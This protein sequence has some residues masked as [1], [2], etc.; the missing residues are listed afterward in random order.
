MTV[1]MNYLTDALLRN[2]GSTLFVPSG[3]V[4]IFHGWRVIAASCEVGGRLCACSDGGVVLA[5]DYP[6][7]HFEIRITATFSADSI[8]TETHRY[9]HSRLGLDPLMHQPGWP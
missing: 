6:L 8:G 5:M 9:H 7:W 3:V 1:Q 4:T 2:M